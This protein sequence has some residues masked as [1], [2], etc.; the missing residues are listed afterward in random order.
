MLATFYFQFCTF[1]ATKSWK[2]SEI[3]F[4]PLSSSVIH[5][6]LISDKT[7][8]HNKFVWYK[9]YSATKNGNILCLLEILLIFSA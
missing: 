6:D 4:L 2:L 5:W 1:T 8:P 3:I 9:Y 7:K